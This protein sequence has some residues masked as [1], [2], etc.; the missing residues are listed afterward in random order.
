MNTTED[1]TEPTGEVSRVAARHHRD[2]NG[3]VQQLIPVTIGGAQRAVLVPAQT[4]DC[5][6]LVIA[7]AVGCSKDGSR[8]RLRGTVAL[9]HTGTG[10]SL[11]EGTYVDGLA[12][13]AIALKD[14]DWEFNTR[15]HFSHPENATMATAV[16]DAIRDWQMD[17][18]FSGQVSLPGD[19]DE[20]R[21]AREREPAATLLREQLHWWQSHYKSIHERDLYSTNPDAWHAALSSSVNGWGMAYLL[22]VLQRV[23]PSVADIAARRLVAEFEAGD[24]LG[25]WAFQW[26]QELDS[27]RP[28]TLHGIPDAD[29]LAPF[30]AGA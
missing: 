19:D 13:L 16:R 25:E 28:L 4:T 7:P 3:Y 2:V 8:L 29:P 26:G 20:K 14:F 9:I 18:G 15:D 12:K 6:H 22:A 17:E 21:A 27:G 11:A 10:A 5:P 23:N 30:E 24:G 1:V